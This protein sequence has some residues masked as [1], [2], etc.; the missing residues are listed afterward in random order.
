MRIGTAFAAVLALSAC[1]GNSAISSLTAGSPSQA[2]KS[3]T[4]PAS[5]PIPFTFQTVDD[6]L[7]SVNE[8]TGINATGEISGTIGDGSTSD[9]YQGYS[10]APPYG[11]FVPIV[12]TSALGTVITSIS[13]SA[14]SPIF[15]GYVISPPQLNGI[16]GVVQI[17]G[18]MT[19]LKDHKEGKGNDAV[20][21]ILGVN[22]SEY[23]VG[24]MTD[25]TG[26]QVPILVNIATVDWTVLKPPGNGSAD[27][28]GINDL[29]HIVG[30]TKDDKS[31]IG[32]LLRAGVYYKIRYP[33]AIATEA[34]GVT[35]ND[36]IV[37]CYTDSKS[38]K[39]GFIVTNVTSNKPVWQ[40]IDDPEGAKGTVVT[41]VNDS[42]D[43]TGYFVDSS[44]LQHGFVA[45]P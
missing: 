18:L 6:S 17:D 4:H 33:K 1:G 43:I 44:D 45:T 16:W 12:Y 38:L 8:V 19:L 20:T 2:A 15:A 30:W 29:N 32:F 24:F 10:S 25:S 21:E 41:G 36:Q 26:R 14:S 42:D 11:T 40:K 28:T 13:A 31:V 5:T 22:D 3:V 35:T 7:S 39:H 9:P 27:G 34:L 23:G 37:G